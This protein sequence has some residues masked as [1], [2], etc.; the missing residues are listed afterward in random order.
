MHR[1]I[2]GVVDPSVG[3]LR[4]IAIACGRSLTLEAGPLADPAAAAAARA[5]LETDY[6]SDLPGITEWWERLRR[7]AGDDPIGVVEAAGQASSPLLREG[8]ALLRG[9]VTIG[10]VA[11]AGQASTVQWAV[12][13]LAGFQL[14]GLWEPVPAP[15]ILWTEQPKRVMQ[16]LADAGLDH[17][18]RPQRAQ[19]A[20]CRA[21]PSLFI[22]SFERGPIRYVAPIQILLDGF[23]IGGAAA[24]FARKEAMSW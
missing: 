16:L 17:V 12:S 14:P 24:E 2:N 5:M 20:I 19:L 21:E 3:T 11:S 8:T 23:S 6:T 1:V 9:G 10:R 7:Q 13:G 4:E 15:T 22:N 18:S